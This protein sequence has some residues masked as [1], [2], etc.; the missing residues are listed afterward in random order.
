MKGG[1]S[2]VVFADVDHGIQRAGN[3][4]SLGQ[5]AKMLA[6]ASSP[7]SSSTQALSSEAET[8]T[9][10]SSEKVP[11]ASRNVIALPYCCLEPFQHLVHT[12]TLPSLKTFL[13]VRGR[14]PQ[15]E[16]QTLPSSQPVSSD[17][18]SP[19]GNEC[20]STCIL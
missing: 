5:G 17:S 10:M 19:R 7:G 11:G 2:F 6:W 13:K 12:T 4:G 18:E 15:K 1:E 9:R 20:I 8:C 3:L 16:G 14:L